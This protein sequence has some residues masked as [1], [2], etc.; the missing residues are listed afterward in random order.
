[1]AGK[2]RL[3][4][5]LEAK[6]ALAGLIS[7]ENCRVF[8]SVKARCSCLGREWGTRPMDRRRRTETE[9]A[10]QASSHRCESA[11]HGIGPG[12]PTH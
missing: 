10:L 3:V 6:E 2:S 5:Y 11:V 8:G 9:S 1:M 7:Y 4:Q 12:G